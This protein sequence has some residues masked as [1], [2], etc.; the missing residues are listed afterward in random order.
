LASAFAVCVRAT[1]RIMPS[2]AH[3]GIMMALLSQ[4]L[5]SIQ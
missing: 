3:P 2:S 4:L 1:Q 5:A